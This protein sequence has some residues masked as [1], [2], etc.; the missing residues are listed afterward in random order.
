MDGV[1][2]SVEAWA[3]RTGDR[4]ELERLEAKVLRLAQGLRV[5]RDSTGDYPSNIARRALE[6][7]GVPDPPEEDHL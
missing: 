1:N 4:L 3:R 6:E 5:I 7:A 2:E